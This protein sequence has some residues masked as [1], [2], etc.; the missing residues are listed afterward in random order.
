MRMR[1]IDR[2]LTAA[3]GRRW[4]GVRYGDLSAANGVCDRRRRD[5]TRWL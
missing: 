5:R 4:C 2:P 3:S 1:R